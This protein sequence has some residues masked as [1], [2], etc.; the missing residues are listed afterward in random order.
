MYVLKR[1]R[2]YMTTILFNIFNIVAVM[3]MY[4]F[5]L[6]GYKD[7]SFKTILLYYFSTPI[8]F[9][10]IIAIVIFLF[11]AIIQKVKEGTE[12]KMTIRDSRIFHVFHLS[13]IILLYAMIA[14]LYFTQIGSGSIIGFIMIFAN[15]ISFHYIYI[16][17][18]HQ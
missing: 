15:M 18:F 4:H 14:Y 17:Q 10:F 1:K 13:I 2:Y 12:T 9:I 3:I 16:L 5:N 8:D 6:L 7:I 11:I